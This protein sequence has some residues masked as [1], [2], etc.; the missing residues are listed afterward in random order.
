[1]T[2]REK[3][4]ARKRL[5]AAGWRRSDR[6]AGPNK[7]TE[8]WHPPWASQIGYAPSPISLASAIKRLNNAPAKT[9]ES[10]L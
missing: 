4:E 6:A 9:N 2:E 7:S 8:L 3:V 5:K 1:M 10:N